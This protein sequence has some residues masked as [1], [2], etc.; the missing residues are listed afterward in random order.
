[1]NF[2]TFLLTIVF[3][4][5]SS[6]FHPCRS[7]CSP[8]L[9]VLLSNPS[10]KTS[11]LTTHDEYFWDSHYSTFRLV[12]LAYPHNCWLQVLKSMPKGDNEKVFF[13]LLLLFS[14]SSSWWWILIRFFKHNFPF[15]LKLWTFRSRF[16]EEWSR[17]AK[18]EREKEIIFPSSYFHIFSPFSPLSLLPW[19]TNA[20]LSN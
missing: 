3:S 6:L 12:V 18:K 5:R 20:T 8:S 10:Q 14:I 2:S 4:C 15:Q 1:M 9:L 11:S 7:H 16:Q 17:K 19:Q 13:L